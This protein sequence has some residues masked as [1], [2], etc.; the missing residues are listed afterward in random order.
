MYVI[1]GSSYIEVYNKTHF[2][3]NGFVVS[4]RK[5]LAYIES[6]CKLDYLNLNNDCFLSIILKITPCSYTSTLEPKDIF[7]VECIGIRIGS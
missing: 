1:Q 5:I 6:G 4:Q 3:I 7:I 2:S